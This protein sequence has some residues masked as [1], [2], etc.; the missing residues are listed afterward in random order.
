MSKELYPKQC[1]ECKLIFTPKTERQE[2]CLKCGAKRK[3]KSQITARWNKQF[4]SRI[5]KAI[6]L[7]LNTDFG[8]DSIR[9]KNKNAEIIIKKLKG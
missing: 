4:E 3:S 6:D 2:F 9:C 5:K 7:L 8:C 1:K